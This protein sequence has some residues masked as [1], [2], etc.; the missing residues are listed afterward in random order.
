[1]FL[2]IKIMP[3]KKK[4][5]EYYYYDACALEGERAFDEIINKKIP[6]AILS[7]LS[8]GEA[9]GVCLTKGEEKSKS[10]IELID[11]I[12]SYIK[13]VS[14]DNIDNIFEVVRDEVPRLSITDAIHFATA[15][16]YKCKNLRTLDGDLKGINREKVLLVSNKFNVSAFSISSIPSRK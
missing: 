16:K 8:L 7:H 10:F 12:N 4:V 15:I 14:N 3:K 13:I 6:N 2:K 1:M 9:Y 5:L 11:K